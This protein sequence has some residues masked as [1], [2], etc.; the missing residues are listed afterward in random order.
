MILAAVFL[1]I[2]PAF[3]HEAQAPLHDSRRSSVWLSLS[4][5]SSPTGTNNFD[6]VVDSL[7]ALGSG[8]NRLSDLFEVMGG[9][10]VTQSQHAV[11][12]LAPDILEGSVGL[13][14]QAT[15]GS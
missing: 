13:I 10:A 8:H 3:T 11:G 9:Q 15:F 14:A 12:A 4:V 6:S 7:N 2:N 1:L 5:L